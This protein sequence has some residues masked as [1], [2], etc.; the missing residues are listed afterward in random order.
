MWIALA[1]PLCDGDPMAAY[2]PGSHLCA[3]SRASIGGSA[4]RPK[5]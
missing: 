5:A 4:R 1:A 2:A 3:A